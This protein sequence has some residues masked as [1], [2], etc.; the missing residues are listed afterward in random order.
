MNI[1]RPLL[2][3][4]LLISIPATA[5]YDIAKATDW[6][7]HVYICKAA[8]MNG[9]ILSDLQAKYGKEEIDKSEA[10]LKSGIIKMVEENKVGYPFDHVDAEF[11]ADLT[12]SIR[13]GLR[14]GGFPYEHNVLLN[15]GV[16]VCVSVLERLD[17]ALLEKP[18]K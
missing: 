18:L 17:K 11:I 12:F 14:G 9:E 16:D 8:T 2:A 15:Q 4:L 6:K 10:T 5:R 3:L 13:E 7:L 1:H